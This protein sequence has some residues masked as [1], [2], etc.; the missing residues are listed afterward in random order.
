[1]GLNVADPS[2]ESRFPAGVK[3]NLNFAEHCLEP[4]EYS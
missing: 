1:M 3:A 2:V 4:L